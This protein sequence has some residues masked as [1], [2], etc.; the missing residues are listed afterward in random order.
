[1]VAVRITLAMRSL[2]APTA[3]LKV[4]P[5]EL[6]TVSVPISVPMVPETVTAPVTLKVTWDAV[7]AAVPAKLVAVIAPLPQLLSQPRNEE[8]A[9]DAKK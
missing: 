1:M 9:A 4:A 8:P 5:P 6:V 3:P 2:D 7:P